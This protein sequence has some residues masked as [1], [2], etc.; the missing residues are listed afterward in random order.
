MHH[1]RE[2][3]KFGIPYVESSGILRNSVK[4]LVSDFR[5]ISRNLMPTP[6][7]VRKY[8]NNNRGGITR[9]LN[10]VDTL[11][12]PCT[13]HYIYIQYVCAMNEATLPG[14]VV[15]KDCDICST[16]FEPKSVRI[17]SL[18]SDMRQGAKGRIYLVWQS[19]LQDG[20]R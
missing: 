2:R 8:G 12:Q 3:R 6:T 20:A 18:C 4:L 9:R 7:E 16:R 1:S 5:G 15:D 13:Y 11:V 19:F 17:S 14:E 10:S